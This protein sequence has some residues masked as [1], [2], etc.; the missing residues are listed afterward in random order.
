MSIDSQRAR[1]NMV[2]LIRNMFEQ[3]LKTNN[4]LYFAVLTGCLRVSKESVF[5]GLNNPYVFSITDPECGS[6]FG[7]TDDEVKE[8]LEYYGL[9]DKHD[10][11]KDWYD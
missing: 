3:G 8:M 9:S 2:L 4:S 5:T 6:Y 7:F 11:I 1:Q 10:I